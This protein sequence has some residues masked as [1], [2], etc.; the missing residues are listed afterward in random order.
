MEHIIKFFSG[1]DEACHSEVRGLAEGSGPFCAGVPACETIKYLSAFQDFGGVAVVEDLMPGFDVVQVGVALPEG[2]GEG[3]IEELVSIAEDNVASGQAVGLT[4]GGTA[5][6]GIYCTLG[7]P[8]EQSETAAA[9]REAR[10]GE[11]CPAPGKLTFAGPHFV[12][13]RARIGGLR[14]GEQSL[15][16]KVP[17]H[18]IG[19]SRVRADELPQLYGRINHGIPRTYMHDGRMPELERIEAAQR[20]AHDGE[21]VVLFVDSFGYLLPN[22][23][24]TFGERLRVVVLWTD[25][26]LAQ[27]LCQCAAGMAVP[28]AVEAVDVNEAIHAFLVRC[29]SSYNW[30]VAKRRMAESGK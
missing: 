10:L 26:R 6:R 15:P 9:K 8:C 14:V 19:K 4:F 13:P 24:E 7:L 5:R 17:V 22:T 3:G 16:R 30:T 29:R 28:A 23:R 1:S 27:H 18:A 12:T 21:A 11:F 20:R 2:A 25:D